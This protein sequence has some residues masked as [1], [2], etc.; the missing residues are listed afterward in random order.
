[1]PSQHFE[2]HEIA[3]DLALAAE[4]KTMNEWMN[5]WM[6]E[7]AYDLALAAVMKTLNTMNNVEEWKSERM[8]KFTSLTIWEF[9]LY[10]MQT[11]SYYLLLSMFLCWLKH[12]GC[13]S[14]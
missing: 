2:L 13:N 3:Y 5:E 10:S 7:I 8:K 6:H 14:P 9:F 11:F 12:L 4:M 1:M